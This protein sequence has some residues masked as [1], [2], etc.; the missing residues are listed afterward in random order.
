MNNDP[1]KYNP[2]E[3]SMKRAEE[4]RA[5]HKEKGTNEFTHITEEY[6]ND[7]VFDVEKAKV[8]GSKK[9]STSKSNSSLKKQQIALSV[10]GTLGAIGSVAA[11]IAAMKNMGGT[12]Q[13]NG[14]I[15]VSAGNSLQNNGVPT[16]NAKSY[17]T[18]TIQDL[19]DELTKLSANIE[20]NNI[21]AKNAQKARENAEISIQNQKK[22]S[23]SSQKEIDTLND[24]MDK[25][26]DSY[27]SINAKLTSA[28]SELA[29]AENNL[30]K[31]KNMPDTIPQTNPD[32]SVTMIENTAKKDAVSKAQ[33]EKEVAET[34][35][36]NLEQ[37]LAELNYDSEKASMT[38]K[39]KI[40]REKKANAITEME[41]QEVIL[42]NQ[43]EQYS[44]FIQQKQAQERELKTVKAEIEKKEIEPNK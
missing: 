10:F 9:H 26:E 33:K 29:S 42:A 21:S 32:G 41:K 27:N 34:K 35:K 7:S 12:T 30:N 44:N 4:L 37:E 20:S 8:S 39:L 18:M 19:N 15:Q 3:K 25:L 28:T 22:I 11:S 38:D 16:N 6:R 17:S 23:I 1:L 31:A 24:K 36:K 5:K 13:R 2:F 14:M 43:K 40:E